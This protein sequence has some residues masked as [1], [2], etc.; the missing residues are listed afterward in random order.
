MLGQLSSI[1][2]EILSESRRDIQDL[3]PAVSALEA[4]MTRY[5]LEKHEQAEILAHI[6][7]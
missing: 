1:R 4:S 3:R 2:S 5:Q 6:Q 7:A